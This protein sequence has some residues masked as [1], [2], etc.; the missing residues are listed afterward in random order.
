MNVSR[1]VGTFLIASSLVGCASEPQNDVPGGGE[2]GGKADDTSASSPVQLGTGSVMAIDDGAAYVRDDA[3]ISAG[4]VDILRVEHGAERVETLAT[5]PARYASY[6]EQFSVAAGSVYFLSDGHIMKMPSSG[7][8]PADLAAPCR[9]T[10]LALTRDSALFSCSGMGLMRL[11]PGGAEP[12]IA[13]AVIDSLGGVGTRTSLLGDVVSAAQIRRIAVDGDAV[14]VGIQRYI[15]T[16]GTGHGA[17]VAELVGGRLVARSAARGNEI[18]IQ[19]A[20]VSGAAYV[21]DETTTGDSGHRELRRVDDHGATQLD[22]KTSPAEIAASARG[23]VVTVDG[24]PY[25][26]DVSDWRPKMLLLDAAG[27]TARTLAY[28]DALHAPALADRGSEEV[29][30]AT[31]RGVL[32]RFSPGDEPVKLAVE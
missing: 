31:S 23:L 10:A 25:S 13:Q 17:V 32:L 18:L 9:A 30:Y 7:G 2:H 28:G 3:S 19:L 5:V 24:N 27:E 8:E 26:D 15:G 14:Y 16:S 1:A 4:S 11:G 29:A 12:V 21:L 22:V 6:V 20:A